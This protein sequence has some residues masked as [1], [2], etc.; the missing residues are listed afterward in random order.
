MAGWKNYTLDEFK[1]FCPNLVLED[2]LTRMWLEPFQEEILTV[3]FDGCTEQVIII[4]KKNGKTTVLAALCLFHLLVVPNAKIYIIAASIE[5]ANTLYSQCFG[6]V[7]RSPGMSRYFD[8]KPGYKLIRSEIDQ[9]E[10]KVLAADA[11][12]A[13]GKIPTL[14]CADEYGRW[15]KSDMYA[16]FRNGLG[17]RGGQMMTIS[18]AG[19]D[20]DSPLG[21]MREAAHKLPSV[22]TTGVHTRCTAN[23]GNFIY[24]EWSLTDLQD[25]D[26]IHLVKECNPFSGQT[27]E[28]LQE[29]HDSP[30]VTESEW[31]RFACNVWMKAEGSAISKQ[32]WE[33]CLD[34]HCRI[35]EKAEIFVG[36]DL[37][38][39]GQGG[40]TTAIVP[41]YFETI[42]RRIIGK[43]WVQGAPLGGRLDDQLVSNELRRLNDTYRV[44][45]IVYDPYGS[46]A[47]V[48]QLER[49]GLVFAEHKQN[50]ATRAVADGRFLEAV[51]QKTIQHNGDET[52]RR[53]VLNAVARG[54]PGG[55]EGWMFDRPKLGPRKPTDA[56]IAASMAHSVAFA[57]HGRRRGVTFA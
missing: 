31:A 39:R 22:V 47:L 19:E 52:L 45:A 54:I 32:E 3:H 5:Q 41:V 20:E 48:Q 21:R 9:G 18:T 49:E 25:R 43:P 4:P 30:G 6:F 7:K 44:R 37:S 2:G 56:L 51:R 15:K 10:L 23:N 12:T 11:D 38:W 17:P 1:Q 8:L 42:K 16:A 13:D 40:D 24:D 36:L 27:I 46:D 33:A 53:H 35:P 14:V 55:G 29:R 34:L 26:D 57:E 50:P 28:L